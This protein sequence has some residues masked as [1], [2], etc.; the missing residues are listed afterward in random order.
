LKEPQAVEIETQCDVVD[1][2]EE[3]RHRVILK[4]HAAVFVGL[5]DGAPF[6]TDADLRRAFIER[7]EPADS[8]EEGAFTAA[9]GADHRDDFAG[10]YLQMDVAQDLNVIFR[11]LGRRIPFAGVLQAKHL[12]DHGRRFCWGL[13]AISP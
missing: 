5:S 12:F 8:S 13:A 4:Y 2:G 10:V 3:F 9:G 7:P 11:P 6:F 1:G